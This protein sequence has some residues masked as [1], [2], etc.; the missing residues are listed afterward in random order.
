MA[1]AI[2]AP[3]MRGRLAAILRANPGMGFTEALSK[4]NE[5]DA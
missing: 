4:L 2:P 5:R 3:E 1:M